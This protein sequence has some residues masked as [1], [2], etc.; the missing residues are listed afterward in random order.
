MEGHGF[1]RHI[2]VSAEVEPNFL[3]MRQYTPL[4]EIGRRDIALYKGRKHLIVVRFCSCE[5]PV[6]MRQ[7]FFIYLQITRSLYQKV[8][9]KI[10]LGWLQKY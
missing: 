2:D 10:D 8:Q 3:K 6:N 7:I 4:F 1:E 9:N 5:V